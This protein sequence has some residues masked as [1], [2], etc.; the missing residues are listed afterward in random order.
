M[1]SY[2]PTV[3]ISDFFH[4]RESEPEPIIFSMTRRPIEYIKDIFFAF[5]IDADAGISNA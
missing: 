5:F 1:Y 2:S 3:E 4:D